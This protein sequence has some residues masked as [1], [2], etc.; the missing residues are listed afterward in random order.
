MKQF[1]FAAK[2]VDYLHDKMW[3][4]NNSKTILNI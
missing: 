4:V 1:L 2:E 3:W